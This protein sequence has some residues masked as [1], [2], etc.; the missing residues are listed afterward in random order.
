MR[1][2]LLKTAKTALAGAM[3][4]GVAGLADAGT[5]AR[6]QDDVI[7]LKLAHFLPTANGMHQDFME[8]WARELER[9]TDGKVKVTI[10]PAGTQLGNI[11]KLYDQVRAGV[12]DIAHGLRGIPRGRFQ[13]TS[14]IEL[15][16]MTGSADVATRTLWSLYPEYLKQEYPGVK[17]LALHAHNGGL[18]HTTDT[19]VR[20]LED[21]KGLRLRFP[22]GPIKALLESLGATPQGLPPGKVY[23]NAQKGVIDG[24]VFPWDPMNSFK[25]G[26][27]MNY[28]T[29]V[30]GIYTVSFWFAMNER[31]YNSLP[32]DVRKV[33][34]DMSGDNLIPKFGDW[35]DKWDQL[36]RE[37]SEGDEVIVLDEAERERWEDAARP[38]TQAWL[39][40]LEEQGNPD[41]RDVYHAMKA[42]IA[43]LE[44]EGVD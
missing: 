31:R 21:L 23:E 20:K 33:I 44:E 42:K 3:A 10:Y 2:A 5:G 18:I 6:A 16:F 43:E 12:V 7:E 27:V 11:A 40:R 22:S 19:P 17:V 28:H 41:I 1:L 15:P 34:D 4:L 36:G 38:V 24:T 25:L 13:R 35:W 32:E 37:A 14:V 30:G 8:P 39:E 29:E 26:E 9:R